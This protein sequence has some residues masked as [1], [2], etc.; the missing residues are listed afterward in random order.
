MKRLYIILY[1]GQ[2]KKE[3]HRA[4]SIAYWDSE[5]KRLF[6]FISNNFELSTEKIALIYY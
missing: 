6:E 1:Y 3:E 4:R 5:N 2:N